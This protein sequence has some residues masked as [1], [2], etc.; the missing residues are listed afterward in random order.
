M[1][2]IGYNRMS[3]EHARTEDLIYYRSD[4]IVCRELLVLELK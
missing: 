1:D 3:F 2:E 4:Q